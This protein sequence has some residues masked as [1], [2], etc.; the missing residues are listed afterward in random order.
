MKQYCRYCVYCIENDTYY[1]MSKQKQLSKNSIRVVNNCPEYDYC[2]E[3]IITGKEH[4][5]KEYQKRTFREDGGQL[6]FGIKEQGW[7]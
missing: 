2:G 5:P 3:D 6:S 7:K 4:K 1:C